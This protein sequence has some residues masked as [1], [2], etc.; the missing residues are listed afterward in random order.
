MTETYDDPVIT[1]AE[2]CASTDLSFD[3]IAAIA[4]YLYADV[5]YEKEAEKSLQ[6]FIS[7]CSGSNEKLNEMDKDEMETGIGWDGLYNDKFRDILEEYGLKSEIDKYGS[8]GWRD[9]EGAHFGDSSGFFPFYL[10]EKSLRESIQ[11]GKRGG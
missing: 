6:K 11:E 9:E 3:D 7:V 2:S 5:E 10:H 8:F 4:V 1:K